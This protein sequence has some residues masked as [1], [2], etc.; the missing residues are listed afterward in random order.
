[1]K[2][3]MK[4]LQRNKRKTLGTSHIGSR[5][6]THVRGSVLMLSALPRIDWE[7]NLKHSLAGSVSKHRKNTI[8]D[9]R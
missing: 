5:A 3:A 4:A 1:M 2:M 8:S 9:R 7:I 6:A